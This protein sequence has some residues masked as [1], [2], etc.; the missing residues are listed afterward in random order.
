VKPGAVLA[1]SVSRRFRLNPERH[2]TLKE[3]IVRRRQPRAQEL[4]ALRDV[5]FGIEPGE[6]VGLVGRNGSGKTTLLRLIAGIFRPTEG[7]LSV[8]GSIASLLEL[9]AG[10]H[11]DFTGRDNVFMNGAIHGL[12]RRYIR[13]RMDEIIAFAELER[14]IDSPVRTYSA[15]MYMR[16]GF[17]VAT[18]LDPDVLLL[19]EVFA[20]GDEA[21]QRKCFGKIFD[22]KDAGKTILFVSHSAPAVERLC[23]RAI[24]LQRGRV[25]ADG[26]AKD[27]V[28]EYQRLLSMEESPAERGAGLREWGSGDAHVLQVR[29]A[30][31]DGVERR[32]FLSGEPLV[33]RLAVEVEREVPPPRVAVEFRDAMG[34]L[35][36]ATEADA[37]TLGWDSGAGRFAMEFEI[38]RLPFVQGLFQLSI[39]L[40]DPSSLRQYH[41]LDPA[42]EFTV[43]P[44]DEDTRGWFRFDG[45]WSMVSD[46]VAVKAP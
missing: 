21:F 10:F 34:G 12:K 25:A 33:V 9:G 30:G 37:G 28:A 15:G 39:G 27:V 2:T 22:L 40:A 31:A 13:E 8:G 19:D 3:V 38:P 36:G 23:E 32:E 42:A 26:V 11:P 46:T 4:W 17:S 24:L 20:V 41:R 16:L 35:L 29:L 14:F 5:S 44:A 1:E 6:A 18:H 45:D 7:Q 43:F